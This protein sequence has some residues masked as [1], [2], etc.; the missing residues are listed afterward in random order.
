MIALTSSDK[1]RE[2][3]ENSQSRVAAL[4]GLRGVAVLMVLLAHL[5][6]YAP[7]GNRAL[8]WLYK[9]G[10]SGIYG[11]DLFFVL[12][13]FLITGILLQTR[14]RSTR[15]R[16][17][18]IRRALRIFPLY[19][20]VLLWIFGVCSFFHGN[21][22]A[23]DRLASHQLWH[24]LYA[25]NFLTALSGTYR[26]NVSEFFNLTHFWSLCVEEHFYLV[27]PFLV[28]CL[29]ER[30]SRPLV[31][32]CMSAILLS[33]GLRVLALELEA[34]RYW[35]GVMP[36]RWDGLALGCLLALWWPDARRRARLQQSAPWIAGAGLIFY[37]VVMARFK[38]YWG[39]VA[40]S[41]G[42]TVVA[43]FFCSILVASLTPG[44]LAQ[45]VLR[46]SLLRFFGHYSYAIYVFHP[47]VALVVKHYWPASVVFQWIRPLPLAQLVYVLM[48][49][50]PTVG[51]ALLS[52]NLLEK[53]FLQLKDVWAPH[54]PVPI[55][56]NAPA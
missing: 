53:R 24:W 26:V 34:N 20:A 54:A 47:F 22:A 17:F 14:A 41:I 25:T 45:R 55:P 1:R 43:L 32:C 13:G 46:G 4:D 37:L 38:G 23:Y 40:D 19:Y 2:E 52:W 10:Q 11:V 21:P 28:F 12:S 56:Q 5:T 3:R 27:W 16:D 51:L 35:W 9:V 36:L 30:G 44:S 42:Y 48:I 15:W 39:P 7:S 18:Y 50:V 31:W 8:E 6:P 29:G 33:N 49:V